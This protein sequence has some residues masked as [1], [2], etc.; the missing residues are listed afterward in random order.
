MG[1]TLG[2]LKGKW[3]RPPWA[4]V[5]HAGTRTNLSQL[6]QTDIDCQKSGLSLATAILEKAVGNPTE[7]G[8]N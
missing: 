1:L 3:T 5:F 7:K 2:L 4:V 6:G 8:L